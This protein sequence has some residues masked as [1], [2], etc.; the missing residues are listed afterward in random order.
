MYVV[1]APNAGHGL[2][3]FDFQMTNKL[4]P[5]LLSLADHMLSKAP[6]DRPNASAAL[7]AFDA[8]VSSI[9]PTALSRCEQMGPH[10][11]HGPVSLRQ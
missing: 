11:T 3:S 9:D 4:L 7:K 5:R 1:Y 10:L 8:I 6:K 2:T